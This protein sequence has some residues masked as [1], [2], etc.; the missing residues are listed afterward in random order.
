MF[1]IYFRVEVIKLDIPGKMKLYFYWS[2]H[3]HLFILIRIYNILP[4]LSKD[5][6]KRPCDI[7]D[8]YTYYNKYSRKVSIYYEKCFVL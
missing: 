1:V 2:S 4:M 7:L 8:L 3:Q 6:L 5:L